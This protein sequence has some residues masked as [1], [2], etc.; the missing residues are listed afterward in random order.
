MIVDFRSDTFTKPSA[1]M[2]QAIAGAEVGDDI[3]GED[4]T[5]NLLQEKTA[6][7]LGK[8]AG[9]FV[10]SGTM[11]NQLAINVLTNPGDEVLLEAESHI[12]YY[13][14][15]APAVLSGVQLRTVA[16]DD[17]LLT[18]ALLEPKIRLAN[19]HFPKSTLICLENT[20]NRAGGRI[21]PFD[22]IKKIRKLADRFNLKMHLDGARL[23]NAAIGSGI[24]MR[25]ISSYFDTVTVCFS[26]GLGAPVGSL[27][28][29]DKDVI[30]AARQFRKIC[31]GA[32]RQAGI[33]AAGA[34]FAIENNI[35]R[36][37]I[38]HARSFEL[39]QEL[40]KLDYININLD[41]VQTNIVMMRVSH[42]HLNAAEITEELKKRGV[43]MLNTGP[44]QIRAVTHL[45]LAENA[46]SLAV[47]AFQEIGQ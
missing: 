41:S 13:E 14:A 29:G 18:A 34:L 42:P 22:E 8:E 47:R 11:G 2:R 30:T 5:V 16:G 7:L 10:A 37:K 32:M 24:S 9:L 27:L 20:L 40:N 35:D 21:F 23:W 12:F 44:A 6:T 17:G 36:L 4:P 33:I 15:G 45:D 3:F 1:A 25:E 46:V 31:G 19:L 26:K 28:A 39:A 38:D 43:L